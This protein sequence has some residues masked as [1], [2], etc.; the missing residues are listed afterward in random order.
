LTAAK[1][2]VLLALAFA[3]PASA[4]TNPL[5]PWQQTDVAASTP[6]VAAV[7]AL[8]LGVPLALDNGPWVLGEVLF[9]SAGKLASDY[10]WRDQVR[11]KRGVLYTRADVMTDV[12]KLMALG[13]F[14]KVTPAVYEIP[15]SPVPPEF[16][17]IAIST[18]N[19]RLV[20]DVVEKVVVS[21][22]PVKR[23]APPAPVSGMI[24][25]PTAWR[26]AGRFTTPGMGLDF[27]GM[28]LIGRLYGKNNFQNAT[29]KTN[30]ID[31]IG[32]WLLGADGKMQLQSETDLRPA[33]AVGGRGPF[34]FRDSPQPNFS[35]QAGNQVTVNA[36]QKT[37]K[38]LTDG[39]FVASKKFGP[40]RT[41]AGII[42]GSSGD[43]VASFSEFLTPDSLTFLANKRG[44]TVKSRTMPF[45]SVFGTPKGTQQFGVEFIKFNGAALNPWMLNFKIGYFLK[46]NFDIAYLRFQG[47]YDVLGLLQFRFNQ[48][49][50]R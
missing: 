50:R 21:S 40:V 35:A 3:G 10:A 27:N 4:Q 12:D 45:L 15:N 18:S 6:V 43:A 16:A 37:T 1:G 23:V 9:F 28:Y 36:S 11:G 32:V 30:Y 49:P 17:T 29:R 42:Q 46:M 33:V 14:E 34:L 47:G 2:L 44:Q 8:S 41:S 39:Y 48:F 24:L 7:P 22:A 31:R 38:L 20:F 26:G 25:T 19:V 5:P 13:K